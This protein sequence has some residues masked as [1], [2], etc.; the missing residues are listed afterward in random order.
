MHQVNKKT[1]IYAA[2]FIVC[3]VIGFFVTNVLKPAPTEEDI[4]TP[5]PALDTEEE[6]TVPE[7]IPFEKAVTFIRRETHQGKKRG[8]KSDTIMDVTYE[9][10]YTGYTLG[11]DTTIEQQTTRELSKRIVRIVKEEPAMKEDKPNVAEPKM[12]PGQFQ[13]L[14]NNTSDNILEGIGNENVSGAVRISVKNQKEGGKRVRNVRDVRE[15]IETGLWRSARVVS[16]GHN[17]STGT[18]ISAVVEPVYP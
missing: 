1:I 6:V 14:L 3:L 11:S 17:E 7:K 12:T 4:I 15:K 9:T 13:A 10:C 5:L 2:T 8:L 16:L 18:I